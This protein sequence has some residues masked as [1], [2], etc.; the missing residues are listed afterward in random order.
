MHPSRARNPPVRP[1]SIQQNIRP[2]LP[3]PVLGARNVDYH[4]RLVRFGRRSFVQEKGIDLEELWNTYV[5][6]VV[7]QQGWTK[8]VQ[9]LIQ[10]SEKV[11]LEF[12]FHGGRWVSHR[13]SSVCERTL[14]LYECGRHQ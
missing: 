9:K 10:D 12:Y 3:R 1:G 5:P 8:F 2:A 4:K 7:H 6:M 14:S 11:V 13:Q